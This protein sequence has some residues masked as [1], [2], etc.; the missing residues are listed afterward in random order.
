MQLWRREGRWVASVEG[1]KHA[2][3]NDFARAELVFELGAPGQ[4]TLIAGP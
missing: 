2:F 1:Y 4:A 3:M